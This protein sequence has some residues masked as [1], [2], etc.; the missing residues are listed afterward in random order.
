MTH[1]STFGD[2]LEVRVGTGEIQL[3]RR[4]VLEGITAS[5]GQKIRRCQAFTVA[6]Y[7]KKVAAG[8][9]RKEDGKWVLRHDAVLADHMINKLLDAEDELA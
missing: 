7:E 3:I 8:Y 6:K 2:I 5:E 1:T 9:R 4:D